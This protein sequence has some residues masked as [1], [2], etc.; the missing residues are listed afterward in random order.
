[1]VNLLF[2][3]SSVVLSLVL[4]ITVSSVAQLALSSQTL[5]F[6]GA[7]P[8]MQSTRSAGVSM[9]DIDGLKVCLGQNE[10]MVG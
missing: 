3:A 10:P 1:M 8:M 5:A 2:F 4:T 9:M 6:N 7:A